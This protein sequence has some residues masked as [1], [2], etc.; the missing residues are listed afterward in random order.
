MACSDVTLMSPDVITVMMVSCACE[1]NYHYNDDV[2]SHY[3]II[4]ILISIGWED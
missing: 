2:I 3:I 4:V 1:I